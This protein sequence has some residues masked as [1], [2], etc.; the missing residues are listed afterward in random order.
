MLRVERRGTSVWRLTGYG[1]V[2]WRMRLI[3]E[4]SGG[5]WRLQSSNRLALPQCCN[6]GVVLIGLRSREVKQ[7]SWWWWWWTAIVLNLFPVY[8]G[9]CFSLKH[10]YL[11]ISYTSIFGQIYY[12]SIF[13]QTFYTSIFGQ[14]YYTSIFGQT[15]YTSIVGQIYSSKFQ[16]LSIWQRVIKRSALLNPLIMLLVV[17]FRW[18]TC[19]VCSCHGV[20]PRSDDQTQPNLD[21]PL[22][23]WA[24]S[25]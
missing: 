3:I 14:I 10:L 1:L 7:W 4:I 5:V 22:Y 15:F 21:H 8:S 2:W 6:E 19:Q 23:T 17:Y 11:D 20:F 18:L 25:G 16:G 24:G 13:G 9:C 12:T